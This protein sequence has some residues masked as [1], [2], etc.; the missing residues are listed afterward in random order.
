MTKKSVSIPISSRAYSAL[1]ASCSRTMLAQDAQPILASDIEPMLK[2]GWPKNRGEVAKL[3]SEK[4]KGRL[5]ADQASPD[6]VALKLLDMLDGGAQ[7]AEAAMPDDP[8]LAGEG[9]D[10]ADPAA[11]D[12][13]VSEEQRKAMAAAAGGKS[14]LDI[15]ESVGKEF[16]DKDKGGELPEKAD[17]EGGDDLPGKITEY[18]SS[19]GVAPEVIEGVTKMLGEPKPA[20]ATDEVPVKPA[21]VAAKN[22]AMDAKLTRTD[23][24]KAIEVA[25]AA[26]RKR[27]HDTRDAEKFV[28]TLGVGEL[29]VACDSADEVYKAALSILGVNT[30]G[31]HPSAY[32][33]LLERLPKP[34]RRSARTPAMDSQAST[35]DFQ[36]R[37][38]GAARVRVV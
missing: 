12:A 31:V 29:S 21:D 17:D 26:E 36:K 37:F 27:A 10:P 22:P 24:D 9:G 23:I 11:G 2:K 30:D 15:P 18:L 8:A 14:D 34:D 16:I 20:A 5:A 7:A 19:A 6:D 25:T 28:R 13:P 32:R 33:P 1:L 35:E 4:L 38:P 3:L